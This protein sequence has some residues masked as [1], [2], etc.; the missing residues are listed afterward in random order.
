M[1]SLESRGKNASLTLK[2]WYKRDADRVFGRHVIA[3]QP[4]PEET[5]RHIAELGDRHLG[6]PDRPFLATR[7]RIA[8]GRHEEKGR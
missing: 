2:Q 8:C 4:F 7:R 1:A 3:D 6:R 5:C